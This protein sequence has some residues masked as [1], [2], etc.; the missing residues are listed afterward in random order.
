MLDINEVISVLDTTLDTQRKRHIVGGLLLS[1]SL[2]F[3]CLAFTAM[4]I[5]KEEIDFYDE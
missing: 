3:G 1:F 4:T 5:K 2:L